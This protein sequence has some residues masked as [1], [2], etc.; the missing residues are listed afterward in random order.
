MNML[1]RHLMMYLRFTRICHPLFVETPSHD[2]KLNV[3]FTTV[4]VMAC[5]I[6][7]GVIVFW[8]STSGQLRCGM[9]RR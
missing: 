7:E 1:I 8:L 2:S 9:Q 3:T 6:A 5:D 4:S